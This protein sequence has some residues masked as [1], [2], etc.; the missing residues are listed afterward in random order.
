MNFNDPTIL[1]VMGE[2]AYDSLPEDIKARCRADPAF[3]KRLA[4]KMGAAAGWGAGIVFGEAIRKWGRENG[5][6]EPL[7]GFGLIAFG[8]WGLLNIFLHRND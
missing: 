2:K 5:I 6:P 4:E 1:Q 3:Q 8:L 7:V